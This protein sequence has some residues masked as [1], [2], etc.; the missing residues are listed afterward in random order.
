[1]IRVL[2]LATRKEEVARKRGERKKR[3]MRRRERVM[4]GCGEGG[5]AEKK[6]ERNETTNQGKDERNRGKGNEEKRW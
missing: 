5:T 3:G 6:W 2:C 4:F 1:M